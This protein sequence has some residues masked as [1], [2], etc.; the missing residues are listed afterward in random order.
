MHARIEISDTRGVDRVGDTVHSRMPLSLVLE[1]YLIS[2]TSRQKDTIHPAA[3]AHSEF[4]EHGNADRK[5][6]Q[7]RNVEHDATAESNA[8][9]GAAF[10]HARAAR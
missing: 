10:M 4:R 3:R 8:C 5:L 2:Y 6:K 7:K 9:G 1:L